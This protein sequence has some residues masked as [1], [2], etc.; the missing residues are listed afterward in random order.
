VETEVL[1]YASFSDDDVKLS[2]T[3]IELPVLQP[4]RAD[5]EQITEAQTPVEEQA[6][7]IGNTFNSS[8]DDWRTEDASIAEMAQE[9]YDIRP[10]MFA[11]YGM[12][13]QD[14]ATYTAY[15]T[16][17]FISVLASVY[18]YYG[19]AHPNFAS[20]AWNYDL[21]SGTFLTPSDLALDAPQFEADVSAELIR[22]AQARLDREPEDSGLYWEDYQ[23][24]LADWTSYTVFFDAAGMTVCFAPYELGCYAA[25]TQS[26]TLSRQFLEPLLSDYGRTLLGLD[27]ER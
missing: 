19:G 2:D 5:G 15:T 16:D 11:E 21:A 20:I 8:F 10:E 14:E 18:S 13:Y 4:L 9:D 12:Y 22:M 6:L 27:I 25:G 23:D 7:L 17:C 24:I 3:H 26:F 1:D